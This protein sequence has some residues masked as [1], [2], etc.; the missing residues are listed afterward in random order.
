[1]RFDPTN[2]ELRLKALTI[3]PEFSQTMSSLLF[4]IPLSFALAFS[5]DPASVRQNTGA[6]PQSNATETVPHNQPV[7]AAVQESLVKG[8]DL[9]FKKHDAKGSIE[10]F[11]KVVELDPA[12]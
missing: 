10:H 11:K 7:S 1:M 12:Y 2:L 3:K 8:Q 6:K 4:S 9:M 5:C